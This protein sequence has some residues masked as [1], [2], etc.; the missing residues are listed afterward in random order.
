[1]DV[2]SELVVELV[3]QTIHV[4]YVHVIV[5]GHVALVMTSL[6]RA[7]RTSVHDDDDLLLVDVDVM[8][9]LP[10]VARGRVVRAC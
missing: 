9:C 5:A 2:D 7:V 6:T 10:L 1:M 8:T 3:C 4:E